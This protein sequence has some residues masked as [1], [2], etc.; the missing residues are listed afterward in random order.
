M[1]LSNTQLKKIARHNLAGNY[2][3]SIRALL[4]VF[5]ITLAIDLPFSSLLQTEHPTALQ[6]TLYY[7][8]EFF[9]S[10]IYGVL[11]IGYIQFH[12]CM[13]RSK[14]LTPKHVFQCFQTQTD[15]YILCVFIKMIL[16][17]VC[18]LP[19]IFGILLVLN[20]TYTVIS[21]IVASILSII[22]L[23]V[24]IYVNLLFYFAPYLLLD[25][26]NFSVIES[27]RTSFRLMQGQKWRLFCL[28]LSFIGMTI[29][30]I[31]SMGIG[32]FWVESYKAQTFSTFY[33]HINGEIPSV[34][35]FHHTQSYVPFD[36]H[37]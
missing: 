3:T 7:I 22:A 16:N 28:F 13:A 35:S 26:D 10:I 25:N 5:L 32:V 24:Y 1:E 34:N 15:R 37:I 9:I 21:I 4:L 18:C 29:L 12:L 11:Q 36:Q 2:K 20:Q 30:E 27:L 33:L 31:L 8:A 6:N 14:H 23:V 19:A 17:I